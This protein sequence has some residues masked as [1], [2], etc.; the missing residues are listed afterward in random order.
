MLSLSPLSLRGRL[1]IAQLALTATALIVTATVTAW[2]VR[3]TLL[4]D[5]DRQLDTTAIQ[6]AHDLRNDDAGRAPH[7]RAAYPEG[8]Y[9]EL[10]RDGQVVASFVATS[11][12]MVDDRPRPDVLRSADDVTSERRLTLPA[13]SD[14]PGYRVLLTRTGPD[15][16][17]VSAIPLGGVSSTMTGLVAVEAVVIGVVLLIMVLVSRTTIALGLRPL[18]AVTATADTIAGGDLSRRVAADDYT[19]VGLLGRAFNALLDHVQSAFADRDASEERLRQFVADASHELRTPLTTVRGYTELL[20]RGEITGE[21]ATIEALTR[22]SHEAD[23]MGGLL[24]DLL[25][26]AQLDQRRPLEHRPVD[27]VAVT[28][29]A[30]GDIAT[31][32]PDHTFTMSAAAAPTVWGDEARLRQVLGNL[33]N[34][35]R[36][37]TPT[38]THVEIRVDQDPTMGIIEVRDDGPGLDSTQA[39]NVFERFYRGDPARSGEGSGL[40]LAI[41]A[42]I[43]NAH[44]GVVRCDSRPEAGATFVVGIP[45]SKG[46]QTPPIPAA[47]ASG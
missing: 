19:E 36:Q 13:E 18:T 23:R 12:P 20:A 34:N 4:D 5:I 37:H 43:V 21:P 42:S 6:A 14:L 2:L 47:T 31:L 39:E 7:E 44:D 32:T 1:T 46:H 11:G 40:G 9:A 41:V 26:L 28:R 38:G 45:L 27:L 17:Q 35:T 8:T 10:Q 16:V 3:D 24:E 25:L 33:L 15:E 29:D 30:V 22:I